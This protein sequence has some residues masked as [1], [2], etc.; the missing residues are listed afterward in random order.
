M[1]DVWTRYTT[2]CGISK[3]INRDMEIL[4]VGPHDFD[5]ERDE[6]VF[7]CYDPDKAQDEFARRCNEALQAFAE[8][9]MVAY[10]ESGR[11]CDGVEY[12][13]HVHVTDAT[14]D[15]YEELDCLT[16]K[17][18]DGPYRLE[19]ARISECQNIESGS[20]DL[21]MEAREDGHSHVIYSSF[22]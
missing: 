2:F 10:I 19:L 1:K 14:Y 21:V 18:A 6:S 11:D 15:A 9:G 13:G 20:R 12:W 8:E 5:G 22:A 4:A 3:F 16:S 7:L 17:W